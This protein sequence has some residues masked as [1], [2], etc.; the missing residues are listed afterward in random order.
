MGA[1]A[2]ANASDAPSDAISG[3]QGAKQSSFG[4]L[5]WLR[6]TQ[7]SSV[8]GDWKEVYRLNTAGGD[9]PKMCTGQQAAFEIP[10]AAEYWL[11]T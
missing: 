4:A 7:D 6:L 1:M 10:Y 3:P 8:G 9:P 11:F 5:Q 2:K